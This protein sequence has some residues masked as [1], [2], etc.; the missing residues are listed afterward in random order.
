[1]VTRGT[2]L[3]HV[4]QVE[5]S[6]TA[7]QTSCEGASMCVALLRWRT[8]SDAEML[9]VELELRDGDVVV[10]VDVMLICD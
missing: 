2:K 9:G 5:V 8:A 7:F 10:D 3:F 6:I 1:M 4:G